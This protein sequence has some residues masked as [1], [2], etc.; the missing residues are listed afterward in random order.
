VSLSPATRTAVLE[1]VKRLRDPMRAVHVD[2][3]GWEVM[4]A[5]NETMSA[6]N[7]VRCALGVCG[8]G[9]ISKWAHGKSR[10]EVADALERLAAEPTP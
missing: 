4:A 5:C 7:E 1:V 6:V 9:S 3:T 10:E 2:S 8:P